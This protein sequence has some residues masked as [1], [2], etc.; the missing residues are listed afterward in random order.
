MVMC[1]QNA[2]QSAQ[3]NENLNDNACIVQTDC[4]QLHVVTR[5]AVIRHLKC[6][7]ELVLSVTVD[8]EISEF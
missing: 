1:L 2:E 6:S 3:E 5:R 7:P 4:S 8:I